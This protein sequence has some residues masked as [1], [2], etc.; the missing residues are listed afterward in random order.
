MIVIGVDVHKQS[1]TAVAV[2]EVGRAV[3]ELTA[4][5]SGELVAWSG[6]LD[7]ER[8][9][10]VGGCRQLTGAVAPPRAHPPPPAHP[11]RTK[12]EA[13]SRRGALRCLKRQLA[14]T[15]YTTLKTEAALT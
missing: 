15:V 13:T 14:R 10:A 9:W 12:E 2:D 11:E 7:P 4:G 1:L 6:S 5:T 3:A 8:L